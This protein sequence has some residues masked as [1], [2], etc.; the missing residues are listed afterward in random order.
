[1]AATWHRPP[2]TS[3]ITPSSL[4]LTTSKPYAGT[5]P[6]GQPYLVCTTTVDARTKRNPL[7]IAV[8]K[9]GGAGLVRVFALDDEGFIK[10]PGCDEHEGSLYISY[11]R[12]FAPQLA[13]APVAS[14]AVDAAGVSRMRTNDAAWPA[15][16]TPTKP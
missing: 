4:P 1:M 7:T 13:V 15:S 9:P 5:L 12:G 10:Y 11:T 14:L 8:G 6:S 16:S 2:P 3:S